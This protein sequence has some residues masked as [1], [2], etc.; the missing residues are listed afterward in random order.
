MFLRCAILACTLCVLAISMAC[1]FAAGDVYTG[2]V[3]SQDTNKIVLN[4]TPCDSE[5]SLKTIDKPY[6]KKDLGDATCPESHGKKYQYPKVQVEELPPPPKHAK[7][8]A[9]PPPK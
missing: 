6:D 5:K 9:K 1:G 8:Q 3:V 2:E 7:E 4:I